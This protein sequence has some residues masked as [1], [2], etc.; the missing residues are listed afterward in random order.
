[1]TILLVL[2]LLLWL[3]RHLLILFPAILHIVLGLL[4]QRFSALLIALQ[5]HAIARFVVGILFQ[6][7]CWCFGIEHKGIFPLFFLRRI[8]AIQGPVATLDSELLLLE[9]FVHLNAMRNTV[10][11]GDDQ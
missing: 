6:R 5:Q 9:P 7:Q 1:M 4:H 3:D 11:V 2:L 10:A 8:V